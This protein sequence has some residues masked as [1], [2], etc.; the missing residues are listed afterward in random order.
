[1]KKKASKKKESATD[2]ILEIYDELDKEPDDKNWV[3]SHTSTDGVITTV[4]FLST[5]FYDR[6]FLLHMVLIE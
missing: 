3:F 5:L 2:S 4:I 1:M 6:S